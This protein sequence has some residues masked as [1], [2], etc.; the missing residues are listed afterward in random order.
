M[1]PWTLARELR[2]ERR[3]DDRV[4]ETLSRGVAKIRHRRVD[5]RPIAAVKWPRPGEITARVTG[6]DDFITPRVVVGEHA[7][8]EVAHPG[9]QCAR[10]RGEIDYMGRALA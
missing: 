6:L 4:A 1:G 5:Q 9:P 2:K 8:V 3:G 10:E 7:R